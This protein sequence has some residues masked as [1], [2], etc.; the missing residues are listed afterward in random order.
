MAKALPGFSVGT[1]PRM[2][3]RMIDQNRQLRQRVADL[4]ALVLRLQLENDELT[5][6]VAARRTNE[7]LTP[8]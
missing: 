5:E 1:D 8:A 4:E 7:V 6:Q 3:Q 2:T